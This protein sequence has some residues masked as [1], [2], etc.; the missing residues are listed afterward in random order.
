MLE[1]RT[2]LCAKFGDGIR[3][4]VTRLN[5]P[6]AD[7][8]RASHGVDGVGGSVQA[9]RIPDLLVEGR[10]I[11]VIPGGTDD[12]R[13]TLFLLY[14]RYCAVEPSATKINSGRLR[15]KATEGHQLIR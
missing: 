6:N 13:F 12:I 5:W 4:M 11:T 3:V 15:K 2:G 14:R 1:G 8:G 7:E 10:S 9:A